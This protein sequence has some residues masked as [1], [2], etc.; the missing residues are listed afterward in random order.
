MGKA[1]A[2]SVGAVDYFQAN[3]KFFKAEPSRT[4]LPPNFSNEKAWILLEFLV[5]NEP[6]QWVMATPWAKILFCSLS[7]RARSSETILDGE[8]NTNSDFPEELAA[9]I[10][11]VSRL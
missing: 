10:A 11:S 1:A 5:R 7:P 9:K 6:F 4:K 2:L 8:C 3:S